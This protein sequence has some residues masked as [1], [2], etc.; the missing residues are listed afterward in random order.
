[1]MLANRHLRVSLVTVHVALSQVPRKVTSDAVSRALDQTIAA[2]RSN[3]GIKRPSVSVAA[4]NPHGGEGGLF[5]D[6][7]Q[8]V[9]IPALSAARARWAGKAVISGPFPSDT[10]FAQHVALPVKKRPDAVICMY[11]DQGLIPVKLLDFPRT[12]NLTL[13]LPII[14]TSVDHGTAF[15]IVGKNLADPSSMIAALNLAGDLS[16]RRRSPP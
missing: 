12:V 10:L 11:H 9:V 6:E 1:M 8:R 13:G 15:D 14:R 2:L 16:R 3:F 4:L 7:D 5:G